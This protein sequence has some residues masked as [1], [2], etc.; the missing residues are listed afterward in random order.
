[1]LTLVGKRLSPHRGVFAD[2][3]GGIKPEGIVKD[4]VDVRLDL[5]DGRRFGDAIAAGIV[6]V[7]KSTLL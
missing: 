1:M 3:Y 5:L 4:C 6:D 7:V 2:R